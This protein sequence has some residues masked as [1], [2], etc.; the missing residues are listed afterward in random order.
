MRVDIKPVESLPTVR[1][2]SDYTFGSRAMEYLDKILAL[3][4]KKG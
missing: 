3:C 4:R 2:L 1:K